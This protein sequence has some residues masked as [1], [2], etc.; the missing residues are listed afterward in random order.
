MARTST[1][2]CRQRQQET[3]YASKNC[4]TD[5]RA[6]APHARISQGLDLE[7]EDGNRIS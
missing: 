2:C 7:D 6:K 4:V 3:H 1:N 5:W